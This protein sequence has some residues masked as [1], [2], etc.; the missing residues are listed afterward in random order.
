MELLEMESTLS[1]GKNTL[2]EINSILETAEQRFSRLKDITK[3]T[4]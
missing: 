4:I 2:Y 1:G 3:E